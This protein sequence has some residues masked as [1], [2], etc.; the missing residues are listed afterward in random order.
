MGRPSNIVGSIYAVIGAFLSALALLNLSQEYFSYDVS[1]MLAQLFDVYQALLYPLYDWV[2]SWVA[3]ENP[4]WVYDT[5][6]VYICLAAIYSR[7]LR[8]SKTNPLQVMLLWP[9]HLVS[10][11]SEGALAKVASGI[12]MALSA[13]LK[14]LWRISENLLYIVL[15]AFLLKYPPVE[16]FIAG[17]WQ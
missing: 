5:L 10:R 3:L 2:F 8:R 4:S 9:T 13:V 15:G 1:L 7:F 14:V 17:F 12:S 11:M 16:A 6:T